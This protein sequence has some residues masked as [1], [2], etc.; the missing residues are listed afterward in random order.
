MKLNADLVPIFCS[1]TWKFGR[2]AAETSYLV[3]STRKE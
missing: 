3:G 2:T 1:R